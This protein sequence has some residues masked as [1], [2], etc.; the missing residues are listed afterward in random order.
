MP[1]IMDSIAAPTSFQDSQS[2][3]TF[4]FLEWRIRKFFIESTF[5][6]TVIKKPLKMDINQVVCATG[7]LY[8][9][10]FREYERAVLSFFFNLVGARSEF[11][12]G[13]KPR[14]LGV[15]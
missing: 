2:C 6:K 3:A 12:G 8:P 10:P 5:K 7:T 14:P 4:L 9:G 1:K 13:G 11:W 15:A